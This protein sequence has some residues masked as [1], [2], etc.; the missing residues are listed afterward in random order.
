MG[1][2]KTVLGDVDI[3]RLIEAKNFDGLLKA[4]AKKDP[5]VKKKAVQAFGCLGESARGF[6]SSNL[7]KS[8]ELQNVRSAA[9]LRELGWVPGTIEER[10]LFLM[11]L[12]SWE[13]LTDL[14]EEA[15]APLMQIVKSRDFGDGI[16][17]AALIAIG[18]FHQSE[19]AK[20]IVDD[21]QKSCATN[22][23]DAHIAVGCLK[24]M[25][26][27]AVDSLAAVLNDEKSSQQ[28]SIWASQTL[29]M[30]GRPAVEALIA[31]N[32]NPPGTDLKALESWTFSL[33]ALA[34]TADEK[35]LD[36]IRNG[37]LQALRNNYANKGTKGLPP[38]SE[39]AKIVETVLDL[40]K[41]PPR[42]IV[43]YVKLGGPM[44]SYQI[45]ATLASGNRRETQSVKAF[46]LLGGT[47]F[48]E[49][50]FGSTNSVAMDALDKIGGDEATKAMVDFIK[51][52]IGP[53]RRT[54]AI[55]M[56]DKN[57]HPSMMEYLKDYG[58]KAAF[59]F[60]DRAASAL[61]LIHLI[62]R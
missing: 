51:S 54:K 18:H 26:S 62:R 9:V 37:A 50:I 17:S 43:K 46:N 47:G 22:T 20:F 27:A 1:L 30:I 23:P 36:H 10:I 41:D 14:R 44:R 34:G 60:L 15:A 3:Q 21:L 19:V 32:K 28:A 40:F 53:E 56:I 11:G 5:E 33:Q 55:M 58:E 16:R 42:S 25:G 61:T 6:L 2:F 39:A 31:V 29:A 48:G 13:D 49:A 57:V 45:I 8:N 52:S 4:S 59:H 38:P 7:G 24:R 12:N 35:A